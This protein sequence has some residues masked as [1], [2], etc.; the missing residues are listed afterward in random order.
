MGKNHKK[1]YKYFFGK[2]KVH[3]V[4][5]FLF[6]EKFYNY[7]LTLEK[8]KRKPTSPPAFEPKAK[9]RRKPRFQ[10]KSQKK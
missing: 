10:A 3:A 4:H 8:R 6:L 5:I 1:I 2:L 7:S 9:K